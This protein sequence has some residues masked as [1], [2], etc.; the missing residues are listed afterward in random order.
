MSPT[1]KS[2]RLLR[3]LGYLAVMTEHWDGVAQVRR[4]LL[5]CIDIPGLKPGESRLGGQATAATNRAARVAKARGLP[6][7]RAWIGS[8]ARFKVWS[9]DSRGVRREALAGEDLAAEVIAAPARK[10]RVRKGERQGELF[11]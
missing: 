5:G 8:G 2:L 7:L 1:G 4:G 6:G 10:R 11:S 9:W 3:Q